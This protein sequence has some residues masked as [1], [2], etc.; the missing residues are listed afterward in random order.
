MKLL[1]FSNFDS[2]F[3]F[4]LENHS[5]RTKKI[6]AEFY[7]VQLVKQL[8]PSFFDSFPPGRNSKSGKVDAELRKA[9]EQAV[10]DGQLTPFFTAPEIELTPAGQTDSRKSISFKPAP[11]PAEPKDGAAQPPAPP[12][13]AE[14]DLNHGFIVH[15]IVDDAGIKTNRFYWIEFSARHER[16]ARDGRSEGNV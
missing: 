16:S 10:I 1:P 14:F 4:D 11:P 2:S 5:G 12:P 8:R 13:N 3:K 15:A 6:V 7:A 9:L